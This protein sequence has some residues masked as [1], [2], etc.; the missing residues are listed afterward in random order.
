VTVNCPVTVRLPVAP[1]LVCGS[2][3]RENEPLAPEVAIEVKVMV[4]LPPSR[5]VFQVPAAT[6]FARS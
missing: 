2:M 3:V 5:L 4:P 1:V 6:P